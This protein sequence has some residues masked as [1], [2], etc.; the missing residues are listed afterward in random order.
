MHNGRPYTCGTFPEASPCFLRAILQPNAKQE[1]PGGPRARKRVPIPDGIEQI[2]DFA[3]MKKLLRLTG[4]RIRNL[5]PVT[6]TTAIVHVSISCHLH[7]IVVIGFRL[8][9]MGLV[10]AYAP[11]TSIVSHVIAHAAPFE[12]FSADNTSFHVDFL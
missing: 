8:D 11:L 4:Y 12:F 2:G 10:T 5:G 3:S 1:K 7:A 6:R 9:H